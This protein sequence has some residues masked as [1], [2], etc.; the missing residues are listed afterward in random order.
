MTL[1]MT[2]QV[3]ENSFYI[4]LGIGVV[5]GLSL[6]IALILLEVA[7]SR[8]KLRELTVT[9]LGLFLG[10]LFGTAVI[11]TVQ[12]T[13]DVGGVSFPEETFGL[14]RACIYLCCVYLAL[15][16]TA[17]ATE[18]WTLVIPFIDFKSENN[19]KKSSLIVD[20]SVLLDS[21]IIELA[22]SGLLDDRLIIPQFIVKDLQ[23]MAEST[24]EGIKSKAK[25]SLE[26]IK[27]LESMPLLGLQFI[28]TNY[29][30]LKGELSKLVRIA[31]ELDA[32]II[33]A[34]NARLQQSTIDNVRLINIHWLSIVLKAV[35]QS[36]EPIDIKIQRYGKEPRQGVGY[37]DDGTMVVVNGGAE[38]IGETIRAQVL[39]VK[40]T[41]SGR[42][43]FCNALDDA[44]LIE[45]ALSG[46]HGE[47]LSSKNYFTL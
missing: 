42:M 26:I 15:A 13:L 6:S 37:L 29:P 44:F 28:D 19:Q 38:F 36:G 46:A 45:P 34:D 30:D 12:K 24:D 47:V 1:F 31:S 7:F 33:I 18:G 39:S 20:T 22:A 21:R 25:R 16:M 11:A 35:A 14:I 9:I 8:F 43:I 32:N 27:K 17:R 23:N 10:Y 4:N 40:H 41:S 2:A 3:P 5:S